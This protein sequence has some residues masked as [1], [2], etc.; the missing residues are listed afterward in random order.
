M[1]CH[2]T[3]RHVN[4]SWD[5]LFIGKVPNMSGDLGGN[6][7]RAGQEKMP[8]DSPIMLVLHPTEQSKEPRESR[9]LSAGFKALETVCT[10]VNLHRSLER[11]TLITL[12]RKFESYRRFT[13]HHLLTQTTSMI[14]AEQ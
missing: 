8:P 13:P 2:G 12:S 5:R 1:R 10:S 4:N 11:K 6:I 9:V 14:F 3:Y 7:S